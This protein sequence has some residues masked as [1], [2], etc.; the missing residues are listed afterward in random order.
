MPFLSCILQLISFPLYPPPLLICLQTG[1]LGR[2]SLAH[3][4][5]PPLS[6]FSP[7]FISSISAL[8]FF[9]SSRGLFVSSPL[10]FTSPVLSQQSPS[11]PDAALVSSTLSTSSSSLSLHSAGTLTPVLFPSTLLLTIFFGS[12]PIRSGTNESVFW[13]ESVFKR[14]RLLTRNTALG[15]RRQSSDRVHSTG[16]QVTLC[17]LLRTCRYLIF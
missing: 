14:C 5:D 7:V 3:L 6:S 8:S 9:F 4:K 1:H 13:H 12:P 2:I 17:D 15:Q 10:H 16:T 11:F